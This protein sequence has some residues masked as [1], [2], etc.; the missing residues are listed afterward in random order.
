MKR[1][2]IHLVHDGEHACLNARLVLFQALDYLDAA[3]YPDTKVSK[4]TFLIFQN[5]RQN[6]VI[7]KLIPI[8]IRQF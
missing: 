6:K 4:V 7:W 1:N 3:V 2:A 5:K 8:S